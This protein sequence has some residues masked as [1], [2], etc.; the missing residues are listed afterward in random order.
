MQ[1]LFATWF[2]RP[3]LQWYLK[4]PR[5]FRYEDLHLTVQPGV[6]HPAYFFST[7]FLL[8]FLAREKEKLRGKAFLELGAGSGLISLFAAK[9]GAKVSASDISGAAV[10]NVKAN[11]EANKLDVEAIHSDLFEKISPRTFDYIVINPPY[12]KK[13]PANEAEHAW[14]CGAQLEYFQKLFRQL[15]AYMNGSGVCLMVLA[16]NCD[17]AGIKLI[18]SQN[19]FVLRLREEKKIRWEWNFIYAIEK[20]SSR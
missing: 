9:H 8:E 7:K 20:R 14:Y 6:F 17:I 11:A 3:Y 5:A 19:G 2:W 1:K 12:F 10:E 18:A 4:R 15:G 13:D 16:D